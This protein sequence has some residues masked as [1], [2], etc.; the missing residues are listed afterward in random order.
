MESPRPRREGCTMQT[1][2][3]RREHFVDTKKTFRRVKYPRWNWEWI[4]PTKTPIMIYCIKSFSA[5][6]LSLLW[7]I[8]FSRSAPVFPLSESNSAKEN[9]SYF[10]RII[11]NIFTSRRRYN[12]YAVGSIA[13]G[14]HIGRM[15]SNCFIMLQVGWVALAMAVVLVCA[16]KEIEMY[17]MASMGIALES[18]CAE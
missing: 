7:K 17:G 10:S 15:K 16:D 13:F 4:A 8:H 14:S 11:F 18:K 6:K 3:P 9:C 12:I 2:R 5:Y 1:K